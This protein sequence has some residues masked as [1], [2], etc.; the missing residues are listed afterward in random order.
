MRRNRILALGWF[1]IVF[2][3]AGCATPTNQVLVFGSDTTVALDVSGDPTG[4]PS[5]TLG[6]K[7]REAVW[8]P[9]VAGNSLI[10][11]HRCTIDSGTKMT[12]TATDQPISATHVCVAPPVGTA[13]NA[14]VDNTPM[15]CLNSVALAAKFVGKKN[16]SQEDAYSV[17]ASFG[18]KASGN[19]AQIAQYLATGFAART[20]AENGGAALVS[21]DA[22]SPAAAKIKEMERSNI[23][24]IV[25]H[26]TNND[27]VIDKDKFNE[28]VDKTEMDGIRKETLK[29]EAQDKTPDEVRNILGEPRFSSKLKQLING[30]KKDS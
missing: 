25:A 23:D 22:A 16:N 20:L 21:S 27:G 6:Y 24:L 17:L 5:F 26:V 8:L 14:T 29:A 18:L 19:S 11:T 13:P 15:L 28:L 2:G 12:C 1:L 4:Q 7:R 10:L 30:I 3:L 9:L